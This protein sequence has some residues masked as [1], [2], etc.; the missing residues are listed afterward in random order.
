MRT[1]V[2]ARCDGTF[3]KLTK[4]ELTLSPGGRGT[5][6]F[7]GRCQFRFLLLYNTSPGWVVLGVWDGLKYFRYRDDFRLVTFKSEWTFT[8]AY[9]RAPEGKGA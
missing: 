2:P 4:S 5:G 6:W 1:V 9:G 7:F 8:I 3:P